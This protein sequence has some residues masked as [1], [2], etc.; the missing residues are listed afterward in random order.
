MMPSILDQRLGVAKEATYGT[1]IAATRHY[2]AR[3]DDWQRAVERI[4]SSGF[5]QGRQGQ[6]G[7]RDTQIDMGA[8]GSIEC[9]ILDRGMGL[10]LEDLLGGNT[11]PAAIG[12]TGTST[13]IFQTTSEGPTNSLTVEVVRA[14]G[15]TL[16][17]F[18][19]AGCVPTGFTFGC[20]QGES[21]MMTVQYDARSEAKLGTPTAG[22]YPASSAPFDWTDLSVSV[23]GTKTAV[24]QEVSVEGDLGMATDLH[25]L[26]GSAL[27][28]KPRRN[29]VPTVTGNLTGLPVDTTDYDRFVSADTFPLVIEFNNGGADAT[30][31]SFKIEVPHCRFT[32]SSPQS[33]LD[34]LTSLD[35]PF[36]AVH[37]G[38]DP[39]LKI[40]T[41]S[42]DSS[43]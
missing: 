23:D 3:S 17:A 40:T 36:M 31:R 6:R 4:D 27:K 32:G 26:I 19:Y 43:F 15:S 24:I 11:A 5:R 10:L 37:V 21:A 18:Q 1:P 7:D 9:S 25:F 29:A 14:L 12:A 13:A 38:S 2:E 8:S 30:L 22:V 16:Q 35:L 33:A 41:I 20:S 39:L 34:G 42:P 28:D